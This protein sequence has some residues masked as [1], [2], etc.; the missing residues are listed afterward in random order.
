MGPV[1]VVSALPT[2]SNWPPG[3]ETLVNQ[4]VKQCGPVLWFLEQQ[5]FQGCSNTRMIASSTL[6]SVTSPK[7]CDCSITYLS[8]LRNHFP[9]YS[10]ITVMKMAFLYRNR[11]FYRLQY[12]KQTNLYPKYLPKNQ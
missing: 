7:V 9:G 8:A 4:L 5:P 12:V 3:G 11:K 6:C 2:H 10:G 1:K